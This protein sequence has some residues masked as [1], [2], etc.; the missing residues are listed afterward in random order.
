MSAVKIE[1]FVDP[2]QIRG[3]YKVH[4]MNVVTG[5]K[6][7]PTNNQ[8]FYE[9]FEDALARAKSIVRRQP[10]VQ[11]VILKCTH[12]VQSTTPPIEVVDLD[13]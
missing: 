5:K 8:K 4:S 12:V 2:D 11:I 9:T 13:E 6:S 3:M 1:D 7:C 10:E